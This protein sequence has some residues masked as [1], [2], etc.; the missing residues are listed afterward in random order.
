MLISRLARSARYAVDGFLASILRVTER[1]MDCPFCLIDLAF[2][3]KFPVAS[4]MS[5]YFLSVADND[6]YLHP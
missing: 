1:I 6:I 4:D 5:N 3:F 2:D